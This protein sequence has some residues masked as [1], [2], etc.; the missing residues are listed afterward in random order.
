MQRRE[1]LKSSAAAIGSTAVLLQGAEK[2]PASERIRI[3]CVGA[4]GR[5]GALVR[6]FANSPQA[7]VVAIA[8]LDRLAVGV[9]A[10]EKIHG[11]KP[12]DVTDFGKLID[13]NSLDAIVVETPERVQPRSQMMA[14][15]RRSHGP[16]MLVRTLP[17]EHPFCDPCQPARQRSGTALRNLS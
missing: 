1:F 9:E 10:A 16:E 11:F 17:T 3:G 14:F 15:D 4:A 8:D 2:L 5:A 13:D 6:T 12:L 7:D